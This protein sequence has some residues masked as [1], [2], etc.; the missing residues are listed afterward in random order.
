MHKSIS[1]TEKKFY[2]NQVAITEYIYILGVCYISAIAEKYDGAFGQ[3][4]R[5]STS[6]PEIND[7]SVCCRIC[8]AIGFKFRWYR[9]KNWIS[10]FMYHCI[11]SC[12]PVLVIIK[13]YYATCRSAT[14]LQVY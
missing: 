12:I 9:G 2:A 7:E 14:M 13:N 1:N 6:S 8:N 4:S 3:R 11:F 5:S 10:F